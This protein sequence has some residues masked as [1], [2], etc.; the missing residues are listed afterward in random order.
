MRVFN[1][2]LYFSAKDFSVEEIS[3]RAFDR[4]FSSSLKEEKYELLNSYETIE[5]CKKLILESLN[6]KDIDLNIVLD[7]LKTGD[8][9]LVLDNLNKIKEFITS[10]N[11]S[12]ESFI[13]YGSGSQKHRN[14][15]ENIINIINT[16]QVNDFLK[17][18][19]YLFNN[20]YSDYNDSAYPY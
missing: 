1:G 19:D 7:L 2:S 5:I 12:F 9:K 4:A 17:V 13:Q 16:N 20:Y 8:S 3:A 18:K 10:A 11:I 6:I 14:W 15:L